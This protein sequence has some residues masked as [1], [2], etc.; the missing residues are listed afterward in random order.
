MGVR[1]VGDRTQ[2]STAAKAHGADTLLVALPAASGE[3]VA[4]FADL[5]ESAGLHVK[6]VPPVGELF[7]TVDLGD[8]RDL[9]PADLL[10]R[11]EIE[12]DLASIASYVTGKTVLVTGAGGSIGSEL[13][14]QLYRFAP[15]D[16]IMLDRDESALHAV[17]MSIEGRAML[18]SPNLVLGDIRDVDAMYR[19]F[20]ER[21]PDVVFHAAAL[22]HMPLL[23]RFPGEAVK[24]NV[25]G[26]LTVLDAASA[27]GV[28]RFVNISTDKAADPA[29][30]LGYSKRIT[31]RLTAHYATTCPG[32]YISVRFGNVLGS[33]GSMLGAFQQQIANGGPITVT[34][35]DVTRFFMTVQEA[36]ELVIQAGAIG[37]TG[38]VLVLDMGDPVRIADVARRLAAQSERQIN[39][40]YTGL[41][42]GEKLHEVLLGNGEE[43]RRRVHPLISH[44]PVPPLEPYQARAIDAWALPAEVV[45]ECRAACS[46]FSA[47]AMRQG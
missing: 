42:A 5:A 15:A 40:V 46:N 12:T 44:V 20:Q 28:D 23:E 17:Q 11:H 37:E 30:V 6:V 22:K 18:D 19:L 14:R 8:I 1:V 47:G 34:D 33:R 9:T 16:L 25:W 27:V 32:R 43:D 41:R 45:R 36:V 31:E 4:A 35:P 2:I 26:T 13:C 29:N 3:V 7:G 10:G 39:I 24:T 38:E 21:R